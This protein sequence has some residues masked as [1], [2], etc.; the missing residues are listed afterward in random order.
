MKKKLLN[1]KGQIGP[2]TTPYSYQYVEH[3][4]EKNQQRNLRTEQHH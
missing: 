4:G 3:P 2:D 1:I